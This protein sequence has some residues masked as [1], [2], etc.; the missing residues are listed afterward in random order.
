MRPLDMDD[1]SAPW[2]FDDCRLENNGIIPKTCGY[3]KKF[4][5]DVELTNR[6]Y[7]G[8]YID[9]CIDN[10][11]KKWGW[12]FAPPILLVDQSNP[13]ESIP[14]LS[15]SNKQEAFLFKVSCL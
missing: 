10:C 11:K 13:A 6:E 12:Y 15:F 8:P 4:K 3:N 9:W 14:I 2:G 7:M 1:L 5:Y